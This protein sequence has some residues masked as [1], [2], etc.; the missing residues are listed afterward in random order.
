MP[1]IRLTLVCILCLYFV[2]Q[3]IFEVVKFL[4]R[5][6]MAR[7]TVCAVACLAAALHGASYR[8]LVGVDAGQ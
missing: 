5:I 1:S 8:R 4:F 3:A 2:L 7:M 6:L